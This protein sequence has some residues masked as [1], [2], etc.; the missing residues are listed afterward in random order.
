MINF[1][2]KWTRIRIE[3]EL[4]A[5][6]NF[7]YI[8]PMIRGALGYSLYHSFC[9]N[10]LV[11]RCIDCHINK[12]CTY[13]QIFESPEYQGNQ[14]KNLA[15]HPFQLSHYVYPDQDARKSRKIS[16]YLTVFGDPESLY[17]IFINE[18]KKIKAKGLGKKSIQAERMNVYDLEG[19]LL[20]HTGSKASQSPTIYSID[21]V[22][23]VI[24]SLKKTPTKITVK[25]IT[26]LQ[27]KSSGKLLNRID[28]SHIVRASARRVNMIEK[29]YGSEN[30]IRADQLL[31]QGGNV[32]TVDSRLLWVSHSR[33]STRKN[34]RMPLP[35]IVG[36]LTIS[37]DL[38]RFLPLLLLGE[39]FHIGAKTTFGLG[40]FISYSSS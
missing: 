13:F 16:F 19:N 38:K 21:N 8:V 32:K 14:V 20:F 4:R 3:Y 7:D 22:N 27:L 23:N 5:K 28:F 36:E 26:P 6:H 30:R 34:Q 35:G 33:Y 1:S 9:Q 25:L 10:K 2:I 29:Y 11:R 31:E 17:S 15:I 24:Q 18:F 39:I 40:Q 12:S 37:G